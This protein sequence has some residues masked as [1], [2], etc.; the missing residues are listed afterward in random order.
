MGHSTTF[1][2]SQSG[3]GSSGQQDYNQTA[4]HSSTLCLHSLRRCMLYFFTIYQ[5]LS[6]GWHYKFSPAHKLSNEHCILCTSDCLRCKHSNSGVW[7]G[8]GSRVSRRSDCVAPFYNRGFLSLG[9]VSTGVSNTLLTL[10][11]S[12]AWQPSVETGWLCFSGGTSSPP[13]ESPAPP[14]HSHPLVH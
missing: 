13:T 11:I 1:S 7:E 8:D 2:V 4:L 6:I 9:G 3:T 14:S 10:K 12:K 5:F